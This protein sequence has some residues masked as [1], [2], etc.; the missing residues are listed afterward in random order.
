MVP[1]CI[2]LER[3]KMGKEKAEGLETYFFWKKNE[4]IIFCVLFG[5]NEQANLT[6]DEKKALKILSNEYDQLTEG[7]INALLKMDQL[8]E[9]NYDR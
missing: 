6:A 7:E 2:K 1:R 5:K 9:I 3:Q 4:L 8:M